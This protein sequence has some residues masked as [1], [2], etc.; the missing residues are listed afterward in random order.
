MLGFPSIFICLYHLPLT[1]LAAIFDMKKIVR[2]IFFS[3]IKAEY[4]NKK[5]KFNEQSK[6]YSCHSG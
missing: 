6:K 2:K 4:C 3:K 1:I 5:L